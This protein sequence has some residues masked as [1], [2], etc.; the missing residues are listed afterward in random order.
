[1]SGSGRCVRK[2][3]WQ[4]IDAPTFMLETLQSYL[5]VVSRGAS[6]ASPIVPGPDF[7]RASP[8]AAAA[9]RPATVTLRAYQSRGGLKPS[10][11]LALGGGG[12]YTSLKVE[13]KSGGP[14]TPPRSDGHGKKDVPQSAQHQGSQGVR[15]VL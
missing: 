8:C 1:M 7:A 11:R 10:P 3:F 14:K 13:V 9:G 6:G 5:A 4:K 15:G 12:G 2:K